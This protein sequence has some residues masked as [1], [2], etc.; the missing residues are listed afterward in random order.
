MHKSGS[1]DNLD[2][3]VPPATAHK[4]VGGHLAHMFQDATAEKMLQRN[5]LSSL[6][7]SKKEEEFLAFFNE[8]DHMGRL[9]RVIEVN[10][11]YN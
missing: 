9:I 11:V 7:K 3:I 4:S 2:V 6:K 10:W 8:R 5:S 1:F